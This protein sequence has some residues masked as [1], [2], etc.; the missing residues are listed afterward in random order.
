MKIAIHQPN[1]IPYFPFF[2]KMAM[3]DL[4]I[5]L[6]DVDFEKNGYQNRYFLNKK[7]QWITKSVRRGKSA[8]KNKQ[9]TDGKNLL[10]LNMQW[11]FAIRETLNINTPIVYDFDMAETKTMRLIKLIKHYGGHTYVTC[12]EAKN[13]YLDEDLM[14]KNG[15]DIEYYN[16]PKHQRIHMFEMFEQYGI[17]GTIKQLPIKHNGTGMV[18]LGS[19]IKDTLFSKQAEV[20]TTKGR[21]VEV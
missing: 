17:D 19:D 15:I 6:K 9:Y 5:I 13:K 12:P 11:I 18:Q 14:R 21:L 2:Y 20:A 16:V 8:I 1:F 10:H 7:E 3:S 4:F